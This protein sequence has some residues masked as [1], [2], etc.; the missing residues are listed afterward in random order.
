MQSTEEAHF[1]H[2]ENEQDTDGFQSATINRLKML[3]LNNTSSFPTT[4]ASIPSSTAT[5]CNACSGSSSFKRRSPSSSSLQQPAA[6]KQL[7]S[8]L[9]PPSSATAKPSLPIKTRM[10]PPSPVPILRRCIS[11]PVTSPGINPQSPEN[12]TTTVSG[13]TPSP[14]KGTASLPPIPRVLRRSISDPLSRSPSSGELG[15][16]S[17]NRGG[18]DSPSSKSLKRLKNRMREMREMIHRW[19]EVMGEEDE[20]ENSNGCGNCGTITEVGFTETETGCGNCGAITEVGFT[21]TETEE[22]V[23]V[24]KTGDCLVI[25]F[26]CP[27][28]KDY[29]ILLSGNN[30]FYK[31]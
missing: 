14:T 29:Q 28:K 20:D 9:T 31:L 12:A 3:S 1:D 8:L 2:Q 24:E 16:G 21:E 30:C 25:H 26:K 10:A 22:A 19:D 18:L 4:I 13:A 6:K 27:C 15:S 7:L 23:S 17:R 11:D 5:R